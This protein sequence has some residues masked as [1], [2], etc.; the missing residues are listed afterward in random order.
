[1][2][3]NGKF[4]PKA[5]GQVLIPYLH[6]LIQ[7]VRSSFLYLRLPPFSLELRVSPPTSGAFDASLLF[8]RT[9]MFASKPGHSKS[10]RYSLSSQPTFVYTFICQTVP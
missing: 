1:M 4:M 3:P 2:K 7:R 10:H 6:R 8:E 5:F 9:L